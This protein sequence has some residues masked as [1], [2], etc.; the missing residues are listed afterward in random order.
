[1]T[2]NRILDKTSMREDADRLNSKR[3]AE[4]L[5]HWR[6]A[7][8]DVERTHPMKLCMAALVAATVSV[9]T[10]QTTVKNPIMWADIPDISILRVDDKFYMT[11]T[12]MHMAPGVPIMESTDL[13][14]W[15]TIGYCYSTMANSDAFN[16]ANGKNAYGNGSWASSIRYKEGTFYVL[17][18][19]NTTSRTHLYSS[20]NI[21][22]PWKETIF[23]FWHDPSLVLD[24][25][26]KNYVVYGNGDIRIVE[27]T[28]DL[29]AVKTGGVSKIL[30]PDASSIAGSVGLKSEGSHLE[31]IN[32]WY[33]NFTICYANGKGRTELV[34][35][36]KT[37]LG[38]YEGKIAL[39]SQ[40]VAQGSV[41][42]MK[43]GKW[44]GYLFQDNGSVGR[45][46]WIM[47]VT[48]VDD[49]PVFNGGTA[50]T[51]ITMANVG[52]SA[53][54]GFVTSDD[55]SSAKLP[56][57][58]QWNHNPDNANWS[59]T[60]RPGYYRIQTG[61]VDADVLKARNT[62][63]QR[64][65]GPKCSGRVSL[66]VSGMKDGDVAGLLAL[67]QDYGYVAAKKTGTTI[68]V[69][70]VNAATGT[71]SQVASEPI[72]T[73]KVFLRIDMDFT[74]KT[75]KATFFYS[76]DSS[77]WK[78]IGNTLQMSYTL[79]AHFMGYRF[80]LFDYATKS[81]GG[82]A[83]FDWFQIGPSVSQKLSLEPIATS[84][85]PMRA[86]LPGLSWRWNP[87]AGKLV[88]QGAAIGGEAVDVELFDP[89]GHRVA[90]SI[91]RSGSGQD[92]IELSIGNGIEMGGYA[93][94]AHRGGRVVAS[95]PVVLVR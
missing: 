33:Y 14:N 62:L 43:D 81:T 38:S 35:R 67:Q 40:G 76:T 15:R 9:A 90:G 32:G 50:P 10:A 52:T 79:P 47:P 87:G 42:Q 83:D 12:T 69:V 44:M 45:S 54:S 88:V 18:P 57:E 80:G 4:R 19:S 7:S 17:V 93:I 77:N 48:W 2:G 27:L 72:T 49:W 86:A 59:L 74:N 1:M 5:G 20:K 70:M 11:Q 55:F 94:V 6:G 34:H 63:T 75:D 36:S 22:G 21:R 3:N 24:D 26:G 25:D 46:P 82:T 84:V 41:V 37:L 91:R 64:T 31:K 65:F 78:Q 13:V 16:L 66:D 73:S 61:R 53:G 60:T 30:I 28:A 68:S 56:L 39:Q 92:G 51:S 29:S 95:Q 58:W 89:R 8:L 71:P 85:E 23:P